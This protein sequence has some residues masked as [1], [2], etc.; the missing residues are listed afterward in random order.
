MPNTLILE[1]SQMIANKEDMLELQNNLNDLNIVKRSTREKS[2]TKWKLLF[3]TNV[4]VFAA[5]L[6]SVP[7]G[8]KD[9]LLPHD[10][11]GVLMLIVL[12]TRQTR[13]ATT[14]IFV[15]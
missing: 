15:C 4:T 8:C 2:S 13:N 9:V 7:V 1:R 12:L 5:L 14:T 11:L 6:E 10:S 3:A